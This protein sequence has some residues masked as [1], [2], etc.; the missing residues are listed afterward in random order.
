[1]G[2]AESGAEPIAFVSA[3]PVRTSQISEG[4]RNGQ[5]RQQHDRH[6]GDREGGPTVL[7]HLRSVAATPCVLQP[8]SGLDG[9]A[10]SVPEGTSGRASSGPATRGGAVPDADAAAS[11][12]SSR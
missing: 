3:Y 5:R 7:V 11:A 9:A 2:F 6:T 8:V 4:I 1:M 12:S 10:S